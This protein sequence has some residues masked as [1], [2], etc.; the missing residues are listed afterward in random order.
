MDVRWNSTYLMLKH[1]LLYKN[2]FS[3]FINSNYPRG[4]DEPRLL[5]DDHWTVAA[6]IFEF[7]ELFYD[8]TVALSGVYYPTSPLVLHHMVLICKH[9]KCYENDA[10]LR[11]VVTRMKDVYIKYWK[12]I[13]MLYSFA[14]ILDPRAKLKG[15]N[16]LLR[17]LSKFL[18]VDYSS[19]LTEVRAQL[20]IMYKR[21]DDKFGAVKRR[22]PTQPPTAGKKKSA[23]DDIFADDDDD[24]SDIFFNSWT[25]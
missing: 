12:D 25:W 14:F 9:L 15:F 21:Y 11:P 22:T 1:L 6:R 10:L 13:P 16:K 20:N 17:L 4:E 3:V 7:L 19:Y 24:T 23:W 8:A 5:T 2:N 18:G